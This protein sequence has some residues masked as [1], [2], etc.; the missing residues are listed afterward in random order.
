M[1]E[2]Q[3]PSEHYRFERYASVA[4][5]ASYFWQLH[6]INSVSPESVLEIGVG[7]GVLGRYLK[8]IMKID[9]TSVDIDPD[10][11]PDIVADITALPIQAEAFD[12]V[13]AFEILEHLPFDTV[14]QA[15]KELRRVSKRY[16]LVSVPDRRPYVQFTLKIPLLP[17]ITKLFRLPFSRPGAY[18]RQH[19]WEIGWDLFSLRKVMDTF[20]DGFKI[21]RHF[22][23]YE[24]PSHHFFLLK[25]Q[26]DAP[27]EDVAT[28]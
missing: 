17:K 19:F 25:K 26:E 20:E 14:P 28:T 24:N 27:K 16:V 8:E 2:K 10:L 5:W 22:T 9:Y 12:T 23:P 13:C 11:H 7:D 3:V 15:L 4:R 6:L 1:S 18:G 21:E